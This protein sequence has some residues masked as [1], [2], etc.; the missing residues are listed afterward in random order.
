MGRP[1]TSLCGLWVLLTLF[2]IP[3]PASGQV[4]GGLEFGV[5]F[6]LADCMDNQD[7]PACRRAVDLMESPAWG[8]ILLYEDHGGEVTG[9]QAHL[10][11]GGLCARG[12][13][14]NCVLLADLYATEGDHYRGALTRT[15]ACYLGHDMSCKQI[16]SGP[17]VVAHDSYDEF[18][19]GLPAE[20]LE[21]Y[22]LATKPPTAKLISQLAKAC[23]GPRSTPEDCLALPRLY[24]YYADDPLE[25]RTVEQ[26]ISEACDSHPGSACRLLDDIR[27][28]DRPVD[29]WLIDAQQL[30]DHV[31]SAGQVGVACA[32]SAGLLELGRGVI[33]GTYGSRELWRDACNGD[34]EEGCDHLTDAYEG[35][36]AAAIQQTC[37]DVREGRGGD[38]RACT[39]E[40]GMYE[41]GVGVLEDE[42]WADELMSIACENG[43]DRPCRWLGYDAWEAGDQAWAYEWFVKACNSGD[44]VSC[45]VCGRMA[46]HAEGGVSR[47]ESQ[48][49]AWLEQG[50]GGMAGDACSALGIAYTLEYGVHRDEDR[51]A[52][53]FAKSCSLGVLSGCGNLG[54]LYT[55]G[56]GVEQNSAHARWLLRLACER[57]FGDGCFDVG[58]AHDE[59]LFTGVPDPAR[60][61]TAY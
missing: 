21:R 11:H 6:D 49:L 17:A 58:F 36:V 54:V 13:A 51:S 1:A 16:A 53:L 39:D 56:R 28:V 34:N 57:G 12:K 2:V 25:Q 5:H 40:S 8:G 48:G 29:T 7:V 50:C 19:G 43:D 30:L 14:D 38:A 41:F 3:G 4:L 22:K 55:G 46:L 45:G 37:L 24:N 15:R 9:Q 60:A 23:D 20:Q 27:A 61:R 47:N 52:G 32:L 26:T 10:Y 18:I 35:R 42:A 44:P 33:H 59:G 31:C